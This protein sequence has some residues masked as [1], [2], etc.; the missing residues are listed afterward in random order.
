MLRGKWG[1]GEFPAFLCF[2]HVG[3]ASHVFKMIV[4]RKEDS[5]MLL[6]THVDTSAVDH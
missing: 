5:G 6:E 2:I 4:E 1:E 3:H